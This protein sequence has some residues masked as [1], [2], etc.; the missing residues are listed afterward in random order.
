MRCKGSEF[1]SRCHWL[2]LR[3]VYGLMSG[4]AVEQVIEE[5]GA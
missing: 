1:L 5:R 4:F 2:V 3:K